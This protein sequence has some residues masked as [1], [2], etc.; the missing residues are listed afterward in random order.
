MDQNEGKKSSLE[1]NVLIA[2]QKMLRL[3]SQFKSHG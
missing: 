2:G 3:K 1:N